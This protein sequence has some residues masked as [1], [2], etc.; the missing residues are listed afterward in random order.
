MGKLFNGTVALFKTCGLDLEREREG[1]RRCSLGFLGL[2]QICILG[3]VQSDPDIF[4]FRDIDS[5]QT[6]F[7]F[8]LFFLVFFCY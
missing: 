1:I 4:S 8:L 5:S 7:Y 6:S 2:L 3:M